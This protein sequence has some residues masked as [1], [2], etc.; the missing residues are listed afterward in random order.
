MDISDK[1][2]MESDFIIEILYSVSKSLLAWDLIHV[3][4]Y[5]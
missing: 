5:F 3:W 4:A 1:L 2:R